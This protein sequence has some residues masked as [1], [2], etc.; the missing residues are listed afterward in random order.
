MLSYSLEMPQQGTSNEDP[1]YMFIW[2]N[3]KNIS[4]G[5]KK[6]KK[7]HLSG[8]METVLKVYAKYME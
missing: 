6:K 4:F 2:R 7:A 3:K 1:Q 5:L 8:A